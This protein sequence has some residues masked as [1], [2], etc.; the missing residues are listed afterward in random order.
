MSFDTLRDVIKWIVSFLSS[1]TPA[2]SSDGKLSCWLPVMQSIF[3][4]SGI[5]PFLY[6]IF[7]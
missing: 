4:G 7:D 6:F 3:Q 2:V 1:R 5:G